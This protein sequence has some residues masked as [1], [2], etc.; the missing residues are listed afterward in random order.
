[1]GVGAGAGVSGAGIGVGV[2]VLVGGMAVL[3]IRATATVKVG[4]RV[5]AAWL[6]LR[7][8]VL[9]QARMS[10]RNRKGIRIC[11]M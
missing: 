11:F 7:S 9:P 5:A 10:R 3:V 1:M 4:R 2:A 6:S 8:A